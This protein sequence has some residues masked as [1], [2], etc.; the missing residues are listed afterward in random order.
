MSDKRDNNYLK[1][2]LCINW[3][4]GPN[5]HG[6]QRGGSTSFSMLSLIETFKNI[7][8][9][10]QSRPVIFLLQS[11]IKKH[12]QRSYHEALQESKLV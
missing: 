2:G 6:F 11:H 12:N 3:Y 9:D 1:N 4:A 7:Q 8:A 10:R 5:H